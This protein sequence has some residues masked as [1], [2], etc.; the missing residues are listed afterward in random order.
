MDE[1]WRLGV[2]LEAASCQARFWCASRRARQAFVLQPHAGV[3]A[4]VH[5]LSCSTVIQNRRGL[6]GE[7]LRLRDTELDLGHRGPG[8]GGVL[9]RRLHPPTPR[10]FPQRCPAPGLL[11]QSC[12]TL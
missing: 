5:I 4:G 7:A 3:L 6:P 10:H 11:V 12:L 1:Q 2:L 8:V 9:S